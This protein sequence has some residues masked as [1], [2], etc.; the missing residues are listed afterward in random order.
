MLDIYGGAKAMLCS[1][2]KWRRRVLEDVLLVRVKQS[3][4]PSSE[5]H[6]GEKGGAGHPRQRKK[7]NEP[8]LGKEALPRGLTVSCLIPKGSFSAYTPRDPA[9]SPPPPPSLRHRNNSPAHPPPH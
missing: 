3:R 4:D 6:S 8:S 5:K 2:K 1:A 7:R 9:Q